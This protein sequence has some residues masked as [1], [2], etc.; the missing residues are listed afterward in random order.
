MKRLRHFILAGLMSN[1]IF[2]YF[3]GR[4]V[5]LIIIGL[6]LSLAFGLIAISTLSSGVLI[7]KQDGAISRNLEP[8]RY[9]V[10]TGI[11]IMASLFAVAAPWLPQ[12]SAT[13]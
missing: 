12:Q 2:A 7:T 3:G 6:A 10:F 4:S 5:P 13:P 9:W 1:A 8:M 11:L